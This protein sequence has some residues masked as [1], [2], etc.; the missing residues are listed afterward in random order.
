MDPQEILIE[1]T[2]QSAELGS[3]QVPRPGSGSLGLTM[4]V[5]TSCLS[6]PP[7]AAHHTAKQSGWWGSKELVSSLVPASSPRLDLRA[8][9]SGLGMLGGL[10]SE[11]QAEL[12][13][14]IPDCA[15]GFCE[16]WQTHLTP[17][18]FLSPLPGAE[19]Y[20]LGDHSGAAG[21][22]AALQGQGAAGCLMTHL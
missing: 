21:C 20:R 15:Q 12:M 7:N 22:V 10:N 8:A 9:S 11:G 17:A 19:T 13:C 1:Q 18:Y 6:M 16:P 2:V 3:L 4:E 14:V 5:P